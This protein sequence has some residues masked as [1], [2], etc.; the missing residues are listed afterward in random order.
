LCERLR[1]PKSYRELAVSV[2][3]YH[4]H[5]H[6]AAELKASTMLK[7]L[8]AVDA[9]RRPERFEQFI[10]AC[11]AD[12]RGRTSFED[13]HFEQPDILRRARNAAASVTSKEIVAQGYKGAAIGEQLDRLRAKAIAALGQNVR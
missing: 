4:L 8:N 3:R 10:T 2:T 6:R 9:L 1:V 12:S 5:Y 13:R 11:E 7:M